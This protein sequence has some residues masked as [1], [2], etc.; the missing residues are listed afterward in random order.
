[1]SF[2]LSLSQARVVDPILTTMAIGIPVQ[3]YVMSLAF[4][5]ILCPKRSVHI[6]SYGTKQG[7]YLYTTRRA[8]GANIQRVSIG[9]GDQKVEL[10]QDAIESELPYEYLEESEGIVDLQL[11]SV[12]QVKQILAH[13]LENDQAAL[14]GDFTNYSVSNRLALSGGNKLSDPSSPIEELFDTAKDAVLKGCNKLP[15]TMIFGGMKA[16]N[17]V[18]RHP[19]FK[20][21][22]N[23][24]G[25]QTMTAALISSALDIRKYGIAT[26][27][28]IDPARPD[29]ERLMF[30]N[31]I[32][33]GYVPGNGEANLATDS[34][35]NVGL[36]S[37][38]NVI[39]GAS[40]TQASFGY[41]YLRTQTQVGSQ[42]TGLGVMPPYEG[43][44]ERT[45]YIQGVADR[46]PAITG[47]DAG[48][49]FDNVA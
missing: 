12:G 42:D 23:R 46:L 1:M 48:Y 38:F 40:N 17:A 25:N 47:L 5:T 22:F 36:I 11:R 6:I 15:N 7:K 21:Q 33:I 18:K 34:N 14:L 19:Y 3:E 35:T 2:S 10:Y 9:Y 13:R 4:P 49:L 41:T 45:W 27:T 31:K 39:S 28:A 8:P 16:Y 32:W 29:V 26:A 20:N 30:D 37:S 24:S 44:N 43:K